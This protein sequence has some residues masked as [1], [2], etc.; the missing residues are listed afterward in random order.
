M[1]FKGNFQIAQRSTTQG[2]D[3]FD[4]F[5]CRGLK[6]KKI[7]RKIWKTALNDAMQ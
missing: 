3:L 2:Y 6:E 1:T 7:T 4:I 5:N